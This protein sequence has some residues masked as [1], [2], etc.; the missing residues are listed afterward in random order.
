[1]VLADNQIGFWCVVLLFLTGWW[2][3]HYHHLTKYTENIYSRLLTTRLLWN[4]SS[5]GFVVLQICCLADSLK[6]CCLAELN[7][8]PFY[9]EYGERRMF[10]YKLVTNKFFDIAVSLIIFL[11][12]I[13]MA[14]E[15]YQMSDV[16]SIQCL[17]Y[18]PL[19]VG[20]LKKK[21]VEHG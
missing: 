17:L 11:N 13:S 20:H 12:V 1:M 10:V 5:A 2:A 16:S 7:Q 6:I 9:T 8:Q 3:L 18:P 14:V 21:N 4:T 15:H 19:N